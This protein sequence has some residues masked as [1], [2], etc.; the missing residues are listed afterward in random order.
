MATTLHSS[1]LSNTGSFGHGL[2]GLRASLAQR[3]ARYRTYRTTVN[4][5]AMLTDREL[6]DM[7]IHRSDIRGI[8]ADAAYGA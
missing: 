6:A 4:E 8:A 3:L 1:S 7:G 5:L 2:G